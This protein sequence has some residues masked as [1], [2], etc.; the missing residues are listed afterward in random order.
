QA[1]KFILEKDGQFEAPISQGGTNVSG[2]Q[3]QRLAIARAVVRQP[4]IYLLDDS[5]S[6]LDY[7]TDANL[8]AALRQ[9][10]RDKTV[11]V[12]AQ[13]VSSIL[14]ADQILVLDSGR[15]V[16]KGTHGELLQSCPVYREIVASQLGG[17]ET[18]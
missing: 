10:A 17:E 15:I 9:V 14:Q 11:I 13:R 6:A 1:L 3:K 5:F 8:R 12:V 2:G 16:G 18:A 7:K 4:D